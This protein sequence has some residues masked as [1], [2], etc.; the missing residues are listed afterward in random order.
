YKAAHVYSR[1]ALLCARDSEQESLEYWEK[2][3]DTYY[4]LATYAPDYS[5]IHANYAILAQLFN[6]TSGRPEPYV[7]ALLESQRQAQMSNRL[8]SQDAYSAILQRAATISTT[9]SPLQAKT[10]ALFEIALNMLNIS[11]GNS[12]TSESQVE[13]A[14]EIISERLTKAD[15]DLELDLLRDL[16]DRLGQMRRI[17][18]RFA[19]TDEP[20]VAQ[21]SKLRELVS[22]NQIAVAGDLEAEMFREMAIR[23]SKRMPALKNMEGRDGERF[24]RS[25][26]HLVA[27]LCPP[28]G[29]DAE[30]L[31]AVEALLRDDP[32]NTTWI[33]EWVKS[34]VR[35]GEISRCLKVLEELIE[36]NPMNWAARDA[37]RTALELQ[38]Q[39]QASLEQ[40]LAALDI[41]NHIKDR[42]PAEFASAGVQGQLRDMGMPS[43]GELY[44]RIGYAAEK[45]GRDELSFNNYKQAVETDRNSAWGNE[46]TRGLMRYMRKFQ[47]PSDS[48]ATTKPAQLSSPVSQPALKGTVPPSSPTQ[49]AK[50]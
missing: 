22:S 4:K 49:P 9:S 8:V 34:A 14:H 1:L 2:A 33:E 15:A 18:N 40:L 47:P 46:A 7:R 6:R 43:L 17:Y 21:I 44:Y 11:G 19:I 41:V 3:R 20:F 10:V 16:D 37:A 26:N 38:D 35:L 36:H 12:P 28:R 39:W 27:T 24:L 48:E 23:V 42:N 30:A 31:P 45:L 32:E 29:R 5:E 13:S 50:P 25:A